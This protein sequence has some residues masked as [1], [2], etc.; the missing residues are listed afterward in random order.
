M[1]LREKDWVVIKMVCVCWCRVQKMDIL[2]FARCATVLT[3]YHIFNDGVANLT[4][5]GPPTYGAVKT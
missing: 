4:M 5:V 1:L 2:R 3:P